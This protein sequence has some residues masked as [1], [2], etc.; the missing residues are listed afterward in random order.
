MKYII[1]KPNIFTNLAVKITQI[2]FVVYKPNNQFQNTT[3]KDILNSV[4]SQ[5]H[6]NEYANMPNCQQGKRK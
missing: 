4:H 6:P 5:N 2:A 3:F 1:K